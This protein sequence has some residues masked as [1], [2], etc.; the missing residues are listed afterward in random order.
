MILRSLVG[1][2]WLTIILLVSLVLSFLTFV[3]I[4]FFEKFYIELQVQNMTD[5]AIKISHIIEEKKPQSDVEYLVN[6][7]VSRYAQ[8]CIS[9]DGQNAWYSSDRKGLQEI[10]FNL[11][12]KDEILNDAI[13]D[14]KNVSKRLMYK[15]QESIV[16][17]IPIKN[18]QKNGSVFIYQTLEPVKHMIH[19]TT[20]FVLLAASIGFILTT[21][22]SFFLSSKI[23]APLRKMR[24]VVSGMMKGKF[25]MKVP[26]QTM[27]EIGELAHSFNQMSRQ[28]NFNINALTQEKE[29]VTNII[30]SMV[31]G[32]IS[33][34][35]EGN[36]GTTNAQAVRFLRNLYNEKNSN[37]SELTLTEELHDLFKLVVETEKKQ[38][39]EVNLDQS[40]WQILMSPLYNQTKIR[41]AV[42]VIRDVTEQYRLEK[43]RKDF[44]AN[45]S[46]ELRTPIS[47]LQG[48]SEAIVDGVADSIEEMQELSQIIHDESLRMGRLVN[49]LLDLARM[50]GGFTELNCQEVDIIPYLERIIRKFK[51]LQH[52]KDIEIFGEI[53]KVYNQHLLVD[54]DRIEQVLTNLIDNAIRHSK[55]NGLIIV[56]F[57]QTEDSTFIEVS[58]SGVGIAKEE[59]PFLFDRFYKVDKART[60]GR[61]G[62]GLGLSIVKNIVHA[63]GGKI[64]VTSEV[65]Q[66]TTFT[67]KFPNDLIIFKNNVE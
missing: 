26:I 59:I 60:R 24:E 58:D 8:V 39:M 9:T 4:G 23:T 6:N 1:K 31:D 34:D 56:K 37:H 12:K 63:H 15:N 36:I 10:P 5:N 32:V 38:F 28:L 64:T 41:G 66:G 40:N 17:G 49:D 22:F 14:K 18:N 45:V 29:T 50:E 44:I 27:D 3:L 2:L 19:Q 62:T 65:G 47:M 11:I 53:G 52:D 7:I 51:N 54:V 42:A 35:H 25:D 30:S 13:Y 43:M 61:S 67:A 20:N 33:L 57:Y 46:H 48:Y 16:V 55:E 21:F